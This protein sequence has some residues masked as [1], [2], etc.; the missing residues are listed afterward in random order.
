M[1]AGI[2]FTSDSVDI[3]L[4]GLNADAGDTA[5]LDLS[6][7]STAAPEPSGIATTLGA[8]YD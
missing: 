5:I 4:E 3:N 7:A 8:D 1:G 6:F 2:T